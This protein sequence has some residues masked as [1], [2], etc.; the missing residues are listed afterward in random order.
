MA[1]PVV[2]DIDSDGVLDV[3]VGDRQGRLHVLSGADGTPK[4]G[5]PWTLGD[6]ITAAPT[7]C[8]LDGDGTMDLVVPCTQG[9]HGVVYVLATGA[10][11]TPARAPWPRFRHDNANTGKK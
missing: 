8:D 5:F 2:G 10:P 7:L 11:W 3:V 4:A 1:S 6:E 9:G